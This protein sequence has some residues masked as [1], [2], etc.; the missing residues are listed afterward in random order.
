MQS[1]DLS[2]AKLSNVDVSA[3]VLGAVRV[4]AGDVRGLIVNREQAATFAQLFGL[5]VRDR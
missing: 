3:S 5:V 4:R 2:G 1:A